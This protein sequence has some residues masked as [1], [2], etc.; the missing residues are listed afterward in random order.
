MRALSGR[1]KSSSSSLKRRGSASQSSFDNGM[2]AGLSVQAMI[3]KLP[4][5]AWLVVSQAKRSTHA[6]EP[7]MDLVVAKL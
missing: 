3:M 4:M 5:L 2:D 1:S 6:E 7:R